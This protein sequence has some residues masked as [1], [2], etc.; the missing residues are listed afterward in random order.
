MVVLI[1]LY[2]HIKKMV[3]QPRRVEDENE[4][5]NPNQN[6]GAG[7]RTENINQKT[8]GIIIDFLSKKEEREKLLSDRSLLNA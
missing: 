8:K 6:Q 1:N 2:N 4:N 3:A 7:N 5:E